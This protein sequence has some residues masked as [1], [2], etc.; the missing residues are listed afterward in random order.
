MRTWSQRMPDSLHRRLQEYAGKHG[1]SVNSVV[2]RACEQF[3]SS[4]EF[5][6]RLS[7]LESLVAGLVPSAPSPPGGAAAA[8]P[9]PAVPEPS[10]QPISSFSW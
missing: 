10:G 3:L 5:G 8:S 2:N 4:G 7:A 1:E 9:P 6:D